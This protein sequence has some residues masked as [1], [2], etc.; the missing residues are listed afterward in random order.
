MGQVT[1][2][3]YDRQWEGA[4]IIG[5]G[6]DTLTMHACVLVRHPAFDTSLS[7]YA[8]SDEEGRRFNVGNSAFWIEAMLCPKCS[9]IV[10]QADLFCG[11]CGTKLSET[12]PTELLES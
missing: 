7:F 10:D 5:M 12:P 8:A 11:L 3:T 4:E 1:I 6:I 9:T 2:H